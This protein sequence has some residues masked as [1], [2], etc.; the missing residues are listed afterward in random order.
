[1]KKLWYFD[2]MEFYRGEKADGVRGLV[3]TIKLNKSVLS[4]QPRQQLFF[5]GLLMKAILHSSKKEETL[6]FCNGVDIT[7]EYYAK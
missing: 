2:T 3:L 7:G 4:S 6:T 1:M 5:V